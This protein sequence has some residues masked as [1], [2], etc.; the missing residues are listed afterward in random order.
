MCV[1]YFCG[2]HKCLCVFLCQNATFCASGFAKIWPLGI[3]AHKN[4]PWK[5]HETAAICSWVH[6][7]P[8]APK[9]HGLIFA[10]RGTKFNT[11]TFMCSLVQF[12]F[13][14]ENWNFVSLPSKTQRHA[15]SLT[16]KW[17][18]LLYIITAHLHRRF[19]VLWHV[20]DEFGEPFPSKFMHLWLLKIAQIASEIMNFAQ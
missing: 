13:F 11:R 5:S 18:G 6:C 19:G 2:Q 15:S 14:W 16:Q 17:L 20:C 4:E 7:S 12:S 9:K 3:V 1:H 10:P 8:I